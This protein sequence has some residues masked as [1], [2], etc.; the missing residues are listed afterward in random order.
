MP[1]IPAT[2]TTVRAIFARDYTAAA[3]AA[4]IR[5]YFAIVPH[6]TS[7]NDFGRFFGVRLWAFQ[8]DDAVL[9]FGMHL[10]F[11]GT[12]YTAIKLSEITATNATV[13]V[14]P[15]RNQ[16]CSILNSLEEYRYFMD[17]WGFDL[18]ISTL[19][20]LGDAVV[21]QIEGIDQARIALIES[22][23][24]HLAA[25]RDD[26]TFAAYRRAARYFT[27]FRSDP[28]D[29]AATSFAIETTLTSAE[30]RYETTFDYVPDPLSRNR[31]SVLIGRNGS[32]K[33]QFL[34]SCI[35]G[36]RE[37]KMGAPQSSITF[38]PPPV[39]S[40]VL[41]FSSVSSDP[42]PREIN[43]WEGLDYHYCSMIAHQ[44]EGPDALTSSLIDCLRDSGSLRF[45]QV[46]AFQQAG[47]LQLLERSLQQLG[48]W[49]RIYLKLKEPHDDLGAQRFQESWYY[50]ISHAPR[51]NEQRKLLLVQRVDWKAP[52]V[53][54]QPDADAIR[55][56]SS[57]EFAMLRFAAQAAANVER[58]CILLF[59]EPETHLHPN[60]IS[61]FMDVLHVLV[62]ATKSVA[63]IATHSA[64]IVREVP[65]QRAKVFSL[66]DRIV[67]I[68]SPRLQTFGASIDSISQFVFGDTNVSH[69][70]QDIIREW[71]GTLPDGTTIETVIAEYGSQMNS[72]TLSLVAKLLRE[73]AP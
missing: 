58:G 16:F 12:A 73:R 59:D 27:P 63:I 13:D 69:R 52:P 32:G 19:R 18:G 72:E 33:T 7:W 50:P 31:I 26:R 48:I 5:P 17:S 2:T 8:S 15:L 23:D 71:V 68:Q 49:D 51:L 55:V 35:R 56:L 36:L 25:L 30:N 22:T 29:D 28:V 46:S 64:Y 9:Q 54:L 57:G 39:F 61:D 60:F 10:M 1:L 24:F 34:L 21:T 4:L 43:P 45:F 14:H 40:R 67:S 3:E 42:Y 65:R 70:Y 20:L 62:T 44:S 47:R 37:Y 11:G 66:E 6:E 53:M 38:D 41:V